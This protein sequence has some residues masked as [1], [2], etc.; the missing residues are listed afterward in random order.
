M[1]SSTKMTL[2]PSNVHNWHSTPFSH[3]NEVLFNLNNLYYPQRC[4]NALNQFKSPF[5]CIKHAFNHYRHSNQHL[6]H[7]NVYLNTSKHLSMLQRCTNAPPTW[8]TPK[9]PPSTKTSQDPL[10]NQLAIKYLTQELAWVGHNLLKHNPT[11]DW[12]AQVNIRTQRHMN[13]A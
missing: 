3:S 13:N 11:R 1:S 12:I 7:R 4:T 2:L 9:A 10:P 5:K 8:S 6:Q